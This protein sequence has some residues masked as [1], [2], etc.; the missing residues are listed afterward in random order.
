MGTNPSF[1]D[2]SL[3]NRE[4]HLPVNNISWLDAVSFCKAL[5]IMAR[6]HGTLPKHHEFCLPSEV[7]WEYACRAGT[8]TAY[9]FGDEPSELHNHGWFRGNSRKRIHPVGLKSPNPWKLFDMYGNV[10]EWVGN[11]FVNT[12]LDDS[13]QDE[14]RISRGGGYMKS[15]TECKSSSRSTNSL[16]HRFRNLGF[17]VALGQI[18][19]S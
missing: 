15:A 6:N 18:P 14:F 4:D 3:E 10:R 17:R 2:G 1:T 12:L 16:Y 19:N 8:T 13:E 7:E 11:S 5:T 9:Y